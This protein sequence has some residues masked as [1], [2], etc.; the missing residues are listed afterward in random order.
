[1]V[2]NKSKWHEQETYL[3]FARDARDLR[4]KRDGSDVLSLRVAP[5]THLLLVSLTI[6]ERPATCC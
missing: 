4:E 2:E 3:V 5:A 6:H 1:M